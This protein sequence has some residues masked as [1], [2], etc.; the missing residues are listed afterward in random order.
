MIPTIPPSTPVALKETLGAKLRR[1]AKQTEFTGP[2]SVNGVMASPPSVTTS[3]SAPTGAVTRID[4]GSTSA[5]R[6]IGGVMTSHYWAMSAYPAFVVCNGWTV[7]FVTDAPIFTFMLAGSSYYRI[8]VNGQF[9]SQA[10]STYSGTYYVTVNFI[11]NALTFTGSLSAATTGTLSSAFTGVTGVYAIQFSDGSVRNTTLTNGSTAVSWYGAVTATASANYCARQ[12]RKIRYESGSSGAGFYGV[13]IGTYDQLLPPDSQD[14]I[15]AIF[16]G[17]SVTAGTGTTASIGSAYCFTAAKL[18]G[19]DDPWASG[20]AGS[21]YI[22]P[23]TGSANLPTR[24]ATDVLAY[25]PDVVVFSMGVND[26]SYSTSAIQSAAAGVFQT[27]RLA[28]PKAPIFVVGSWPYN[29]VAARP[30]I[31]QQ[32]AT[33]AILAGLQ[34]ADPSG[35][36]SGLSAF[37]DPIAAGILTGTGS[38]T[39]NAG[40]GNSDWYISGAAGNPHPNNGGHDF[41]GR[42]LASAVKAKL[43]YVP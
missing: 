11:N 7:E 34:Q 41:Y 10:Y 6:Q 8:L 31:N 30:L 32:A 35:Y 36:A 27:T 13:Y 20:G 14:A 42:W 17:D 15:R 16:A 3:A 38:D 43:Q 5:Y 23:G 19:W 28:L 9:I 26:Y 40:N 29:N 24:L 22:N 33:A 21:G 4:P 39:A 18:L 12:A 1:L 37:V 2:L 25:S